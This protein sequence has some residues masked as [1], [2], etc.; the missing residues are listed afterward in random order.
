MEKVSKNMLVFY[1]KI[2]SGLRNLNIVTKNRN[3]HKEIFDLLNQIEKERNK[4]PT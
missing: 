4:T 1:K 2:W 3:C